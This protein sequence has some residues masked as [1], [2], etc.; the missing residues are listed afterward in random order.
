MSDLSL[1]SPLRDLIS[2]P[3]HIDAADFVLKLQQ[4]VSEHERTLSDYVVTESIAASIGEAL[5]LVDDAL[6][7]RE[8]RGAYVH[9]SFGS[10][11]SHFM[12]VLHLL[13]T[14]NIRARQIDGIESVVATHRDVLERNLLAI[15]FNLL[16]A[17]SFEDAIFGGY[18]E[19]VAAKHPDAPRPVLHASDQLLD[20][21][22]G[23]REQFGDE[24][25]FRAISTDSDDG[26]GA[27]SSGWDAASFDAAASQPPGHPDRDRLVRDLTDTLFTAYVRAGA[28]LDMTS[29]LRAMTEH[30]KS[31]GYD[32]IVLFLDELVLWLGQHLQNDDFVQGEIEK[33]AKLVETATARLAVPIVSFVARQRDLKDFLGS[34]NFGVEREAKSQLFQY[35]DDRFQKITLQAAD[36]PR[37]VK[38]RLLRPTSP[39]AAVV[40]DAALQKVKGNRAAWG[41]L[42]AD[43][44]NADERDF[45]AVYP[46]SPALV[47]AMIALSS[48]M[49]RE[50]TAL[51]LMG[52]LLAKGRDWLTA[53]DVVP[54]GDLYEPVVLGDSKPLTADM[55]KHFEISQRFYTM[56]MRP[57]LLGKHSLTEAQAAALP[58]NHAF[59]TEDRLAKTLLI[60]AL[61][62]DARSLSRLTAQRLAALNYGTVTAFVP[63]MEAQQVLGL[64]REWSKQFGEIT[65]G[66]GADPVIGATLTGVD[67][68]SI[69]QNIAAED[70]PQARRELVRRIV[71]DELGLADT[72]VLG[73]GRPF[74]RVWRGQRRTASVVFGNVRDK[75]DVAD[76]TLVHR[77]DD[78]VVVI[79]FPYDDGHSPADDLQRIQDLRAGDGAGS[80]TLAW[81]PN[82]LT[83][84]RLQDLGKLVLLERIAPK[85]RFEQNTQ[86]L[87][88]TD[89]EPARQ[90]L[91]AQRRS[92]KGSLVTALRQAYGVHAADRSN[93]TEGIEVSE[94]FAS[95]VADLA[96]PPPVTGTLGSGL[97]HALDAAWSNEH[98]EHPRLGD[99][100]LSSRR[101]ADA[102]ALVLRADEE[103]GGRRQGLSAAEQR[104]LRDVA[105]PLGLGAIN[106][107]VL[108]VL[109]S[110]FE[111][112]N[113]LARWA[114]EADDQPSV[115]A[116]RAHLAPWGMTTPM[117]DAVLLAWAAIAKREWVRGSASVSVDIGQL[118][119]DLVSRLAALPDADEWST[120]NARAR[121]IFRAPEERH[122]GPA[123][124]VR[125][126]KSLDGA[127]DGAAASTLVERLRAHADTLALDLD[128]AS[129]R[130]HTAERALELITQLRAATAPLERVQLLASF[131]LVDSAATARSVASAADVARALDVVDW[132]A[133]AAAQGRGDAAFDDAFARLQEAARLDESIVPLGVRLHEASEEARRVVI[134]AA[135]ASAQA[136]VSASTR[137][138]DRVSTSIAVPSQ[139]PVSEQVLPC[140]LRADS[141][142]LDAELEALHARL[143]AA[144]ANGGIATVTWSIERR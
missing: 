45:G 107:N 73:L 48:L 21:A 98:P 142:T 118:S 7:K 84:A 121:S 122:L 77:G 64:V 2:M 91:E 99:E 27:L 115:A 3:T 59:V 41:V 30:A 69:L 102:L 8:A 105:V 71:L 74:T 33:V 63:G 96:V 110:T 78:W 29:G 61:A 12:A 126:A 81:V 111:W 13:L 83:E 37:I 31:L 57:F 1:T 67:Y 17:R 36:L 43:E 40:L 113:D 52:E 47:D 101:L 90:A 139:D 18:L 106:E 51:R 125:L 138:Q 120:A 75:Q 11:K 42:L 58:R 97:Q 55:Q 132:Q 130:L 22:R 46:F 20:D 95:L 133:L 76:S 65:V 87:P 6:T 53:S 103:D 114:A 14:G 104:L 25:F 56:K 35:W 129:G 50:R 94:Q 117:E 70:T 38:Q 144:L 137:E 86:H 72:S 26:W 39:E 92:L 127:L 116:L 23:Q 135:P 32:G 19:V 88:L 119:P 93:V 49:Q 82:F 124:V 9:G 131:T 108:V 141:A 143:K 34:S 10:G 5:Q 60:A 140:T 89:R 28:W 123:A 136:P 79:D 15:D 128:A 44:A 54:V 66:E 85:E 62:P 112:R 100:E 109:P 134:Q 24:A 80:R 16:G 4:G 68:D